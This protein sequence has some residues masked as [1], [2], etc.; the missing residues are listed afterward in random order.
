M[1]ELEPGNTTDAHY[2]RWC[3]EEW[4]LILTGTPAL[5]HGEGQ[6]TLS[7][8]DICCFPEGPSRAHQLR[9]DG[10]V[11][12]RLIVFSTSTARPM[13]TFCPDQDTVLIPFS[14]REGLLFR[15]GDQIEDNRAGEPGSG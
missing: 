11:P 2:H 3:R 12:S 8:G 10:G 5:R 7:A 4:V 13:S 15:F 9:N 1:Y 6:T 14:D